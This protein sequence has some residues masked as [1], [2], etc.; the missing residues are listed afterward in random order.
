MSSQRI[1]VEVDEDG[2]LEARVVGANAFSGKVPMPLTAAADDLDVRLIRL[3]ERWL[4]VRG[5]PW[6][7]AEIR[8]FGALL[9]RALFPPEV[10]TWIRKA[11]EGHALVRLT[12]TFPSE[13]QH[14]RLASVPWEFL[15]Q[16]DKQFEQG[17]FLAGQHGY[18][19]SRHIPS[20]RGIPHLDPI[21]RPR[22][23]AIV[24][25][26]K[27][28][29]KVDA[30]GVLAGIHDA[31]K[32]CDLEPE[33]VYSPSATELGEIVASWQPHLVQFMGHG[34]Y[35]PGRGE[36]RLAFADPG[37]ETNW[38]PD[39]RMA[40]LLVSPNWVPRAVVLHACDG[41]ATDYEAGF[42]GVAPQLCRAGVQCVV[43]MQYPVTNN[44]AT[45]F[46]TTFY[47]ELARRQPPD[48]AVQTARS[49]IAAPEIGAGLIGVPVV[50]LHSDDP[51]L[52]EPEQEGKQ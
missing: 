51:L 46:S 25:Q 34:R 14:A 20:R 2:M 12:L 13:S 26:P 38:V 22:L 48:V 33:V 43:A 31:A 35:D 24:S 8:T 40:D 18:T 3:F 41:G 28:E 30:D 45:S 52:A 29:Q 39:A 7:P 1:A 4:Q 10:W 17:W 47:R 9:H 5:R 36:G 6:I 27:T 32:Q 16:P 42:A 15:Y 44:T 49:V 37:G 11:S 23:L 21:V 50:Y 19:L